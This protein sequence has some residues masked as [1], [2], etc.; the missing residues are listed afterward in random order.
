MSDAVT[1]TSVLGTSWLDPTVASAAGGTDVTRT[2]AQDAADAAT[3]QQTQVNRLIRDTVASPKFDRNTGAPALWV[4]TVSDY[5]RPDQQ[6]QVLRDLQAQ[7]GLRPDAI[8]YG[9]G[10][11]IYTDPRTQ[12]PTLFQPGLLTA[13]GKS[14]AGW[15]GTA[16]EIGGAVLGALG[17]TF[18]GGPAGGI[19][20]AGA[21]AAG[22]REAV[23]GLL[24]S[25][26]GVTDPRTT[27]QV[28]TDVGTTAALNA[29][30]QALIPG[31][32]R[33]TR[34]LTPSLRGVAT[35]AGPEASAAADA[36]GIAKPASNSI[37]N[38]DAQTR[39]NQRYGENLNITGGALSESPN[40][41]R[42]E[43]VSSV[44]P[45]SQ[46]PGQWNQS[47]TDSGRMADRIALDISGGGGANPTAAATAPT[48]GR[49]ATGDVLQDS[50]QG[51]IQGFQ[52]RERQMMGDVLNAA[53]DAR[54]QLQKFEQVR[55]SLQPVPGR[56]DIN[57]AA[58]Q[59]ALNTADS[60]LN[61]ALQPAGLGGGYFADLGS[62]L[63]LRTNLGQEAFGT[64]LPGTRTPGSQQY[65]QG[66]YNAL[67][68]DIRGGLNDTAAQLLND[69]DQYVQMM[70]DPASQNLDMASMKDLGR[71]AAKTPDAL[72]QSMIAGNPAAGRQLSNLINRMVSEGQTDQANQ[73]M[74]VIFRNIGAPT[75]GATGAANAAQFS[76]LVFATKWAAMPDSVKTAFRQNMSPE[77]YAAINDL[78]QTAKA[79]QAASRSYNFSQSGNTVNVMGM[80]TSGIGAAAGALG[81]H[82][83][84]L[85]TWLGTYFGAPK[86]IQMMQN[87]TFVRWLAGTARQAAVGRPGW[88]ANAAGRLGAVGLNPADHAAIQNMLTGNQQQ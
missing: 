29:A 11:F 36:L 63:Q 82:I 6:L 78:A 73:L 4:A 9:D 61:N 10:N 62:A 67:N 24:R 54:I 45:F 33:V 85:M 5:S 72:A 30:G 39:L 1:P 57:F 50:S 81:G 56:G 23:G 71:L 49:Q 68:T 40:L 59:Q 65:M 83:G 46:V 80:T 41:I 16:G 55:N 42:A 37:G 64:A 38:I 74:A 77:L 31:I 2:A 13:P 86:M 69:H 47:I 70:R 51:L 20:G 52:Q 44:S 53:P 12:R 22:G 18:A 87:P 19:A 76:P 17:G 48:V 84:P 35:E 66:L 3:A 14:I 75:S 60:V 58:K 7:A 79:Q 25:A 88:M 32:S 43:N 15:A 8:P 26:T 21:G 34:A 27:G 28:L